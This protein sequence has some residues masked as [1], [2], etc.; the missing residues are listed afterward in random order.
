METSP[1]KA[2]ILAV[3][4]TPFATPSIGVGISLKRSAIPDRCPTSTELNSFLQSE[5]GIEKVRKLC[6]SQLDEG[7]SCS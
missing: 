4:T 5:F 3:P 2:H 1:A 7:V 6:V